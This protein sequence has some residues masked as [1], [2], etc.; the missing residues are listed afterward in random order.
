LFHIFKQLVPLYT[1]GH[2]DTIRLVLYHCGRSAAKLGFDASKLASVPVVGAAGGESSLCRAVT[3]YD[4]ASGDASVCIA[5]LS[6]LSRWGCT[7]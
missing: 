2:L 6:T 3:L 5:L 1:L 4:A 7:S